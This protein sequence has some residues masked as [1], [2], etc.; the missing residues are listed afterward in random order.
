MKFVT[1][2]IAAPLFLIMAVLLG[3]A[4]T[5]AGEREDAATKL[6]EPKSSVVNVNQWVIH[7]IA[8]WNEHDAVRRR[9]LIAQTWADAG[10]YVDAHRNAKGPEALDAM[11]AKAQ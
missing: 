3:S 6:P 4:V 10:A 8:C 5:T 9:S 2:W 11:L 7:Y 1:R